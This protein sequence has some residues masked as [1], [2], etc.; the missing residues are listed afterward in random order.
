MELL[1]EKFTALETELKKYVDSSLFPSLDEI[2]HSDLVF[3]ITMTF[4][5]V[6]SADAFRTKITELISSNQIAVT[7]TE[8][9]HIVPLVQEFVLWLRV[10]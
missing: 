7:A 2:D 6:T 1:V 9:E 5:G 4:M 3:Y 10:L 8:L